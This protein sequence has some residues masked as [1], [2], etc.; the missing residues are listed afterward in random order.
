MVGWDFSSC[1]RWRTGFMQDFTSSILALVCA[2]GS[3]DQDNWYRKSAVA[4]S[5]V[6]CR[7]IT[8]VSNKQFP[9]GI[10]SPH[11]PQKS[12]KRLLAFHRAQKGKPWSR[13]QAGPKPLPIWTHGPTRR[14]YG[15]P[16]KG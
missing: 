16:N 11:L 12:G 13:K 5:G 3:F 8:A 2:P 7:I 15:R 1:A 6:S 10:A 4:R 9:L 14:D